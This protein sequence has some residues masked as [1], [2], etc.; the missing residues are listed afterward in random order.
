MAA[1]NQH[2][3][4]AE[5]EGK[6]IDFISGRWNLTTRTDAV[7]SYLKRGASVLASDAEQ[8][9]CLH[10]CALQGYA[11]SVNVVLA[12]VKHA[13]LPHVDK[14]Q[15]LLDK[16]DSDGYTAMAYAAANNSHTVIRTLLQH[17]ADARLTDDGG[18]TPLMLSIINQGDSST[19][20]MLA[21]NS[22]VDAKNKDG[23]TALMLACQSGRTPA[24]KILVKHGADVNVADKFQ[25]TALIYAAEFGKFSLIKV[26]LETQDID[27]GY[28][29]H[30]GTALEVA[31][32]MKLSERIIEAIRNCKVQRLS[33]GGESHVQ[34]MRGARKR[35]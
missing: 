32:K 1:A 2:H 23:Q 22:D 19:V 7:A 5:L 33:K 28:S 12:C 3:K 4:H 11:E 8:R 14:L 17:G 24:S 16:K 20:T 9:T 35:W 26:L 10:W 21:S 31:R 13:S 29:S 6:M 25:K 27:V 34:A 30:D 18:F 15:E